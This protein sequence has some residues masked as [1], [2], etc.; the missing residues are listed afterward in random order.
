LAPALQIPLQYGAS[1]EVQG[2]AKSELV[3]DPPK[4]RKK[5]EYTLL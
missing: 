1:F 4:I 3:I 5:V 2:T